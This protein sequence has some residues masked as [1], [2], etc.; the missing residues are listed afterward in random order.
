MKYTELSV[1]NVEKWEIGEDQRV[2]R[3]IQR[4][5]AKTDNKACFDSGCFVYN[6]TSF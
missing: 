4:P 5:P 6:L 2:L 1:Q 3:L